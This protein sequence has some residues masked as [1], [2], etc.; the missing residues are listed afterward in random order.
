MNESSC[1][2]VSVNAMNKSSIKQRAIELGFDLVGVTDA[3][4]VGYEHAQPLG[5][6]LDANYNGEMKYMAANIEKGV[7][8]ALLLE[9]AK[10]VICVGLN[11]TAKTPPIPKEASGKI[12]LYACYPDYHTFIKQRLF[13]LADFIK[14]KDKNCRFKA[15]V[16]SVPLLE[17][18]LAQRAGLGFIGKNH[19]LINPA[20]GPQ[21]FLG[22]LITTLELEPD[23]PSEGNCGDCDK[24]LNACPTGA[25]RRD[26]F[27]DARQCISYLTIEHKGQI[28]PELAEK[29][30]DS[31]FGCDR[32]VFACPY[33]QKAL[34]SANKDFQF[35]PKRAVMELKKIISLTKPQFESQFTGTCILRCGIEKL[36]QNARICLEN[37]R[38]IEKNNFN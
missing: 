13:K 9:G 36:K 24:C 35:Q 14:S 17:R 1:Q 2:A 34:P 21:I 27:L 29:I 19:M 18:A 16:D 20:L 23:Q 12:A 15:C 38:G 11:Y 3:A 5:R 31:V 8:P 37:H 22:E 7:N 33:Y 4:P 10:S 32:C 30:G 25:L 26:C 28:S 6:W